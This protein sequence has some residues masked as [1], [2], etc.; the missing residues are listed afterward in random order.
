M[1]EIRKTD[2]KPREERTY[3]ALAEVTLPR[4]GTVPEGALDMPLV[5]FINTFFSYAEPA[6]R[7]GFKIALFLLEFMPLFIIFRPRRF[8][9]LSTTQR[10]VMLNKM[11]GSSI[12]AVRGIYL[13]LNSLIQMC[14]YTQPSIMDKVGYIG[15]REAVR[16]VPK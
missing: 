5:N 4:G 13:A 12:Y 15:Y 3:K 8:S 9:S 10:D 2:L 14:F 1:N 7:L 11:R 6:T 16:K